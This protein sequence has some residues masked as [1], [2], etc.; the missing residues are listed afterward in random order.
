MGGPFLVPALPGRHPNSNGVGVPVEF[1]LQ[2][3]LPIIEL[4]QNNNKIHN[5]QN[6]KFF[7]K[8]RINII[9]FSFCLRFQY[10]VALI[11]SLF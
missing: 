6:I 4:M 11:L 10:D 2:S 8:D 7:I 1:Q 9:D 5:T 3:P